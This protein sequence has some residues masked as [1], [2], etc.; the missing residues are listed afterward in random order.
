MESSGTLSKT[1]RKK[2]MHEMQVLGE[3][4]V[5]LKHDQLAQMGL[6]DTLLDAV[7]EAQRVKTR[8]ARRRQLQYVG[9]LMRDVDAAPIRERLAILGGRSR[10]HSAWLHLL[11]RWR[12]RLLTDEDSFRAFAEEHPV[13]NLQRLRALCRTARKERE[14]GRPPRNYRALFDA[15]RAIIPPPRAPGATETTDETH[16]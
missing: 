16:E 12:E 1:Q 8:E 6:P 4:L 11:E 13:E 2:Q 7:L 14:E 15:L 3:Q 9:R 10:Q 5:K